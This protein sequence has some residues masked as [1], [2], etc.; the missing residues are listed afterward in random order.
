[1]EVD[2]L[3]FVQDLSHELANAHSVDPRLSGE[4]G[5]NKRLR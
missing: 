3:V 1:L 2:L 5:L 4:A